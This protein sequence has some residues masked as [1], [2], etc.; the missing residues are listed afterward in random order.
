MQKVGIPLFFKGGKLSIDNNWK[1]RYSSVRQVCRRVELFRSLKNLIG[2]TVRALDGNIGT[3]ADFYIDDFDWMVKYVV[4][5]VEGTQVPRLSLLAPLAFGDLENTPEEGVFPVQVTRAT[6]LN[7]PLLR[8][9]EPVSLRHLTAIHSY[10][11]WPIYWEIGGSAEP[12][13]IEEDMSGYPIVEM[14]TDV[15]AQRDAFSHSE[16]PHL[17]SVKEV[18]GYYINTR[19]GVQAA[20]VVDFLAED[21]DWRVM[22]MVANAG[23]KAENRYVLLSP[24][25]VDEIHWPDHEINLDLKT[26]TVQK[27]PPYDPEMI[28][29]REYEEQLFHHYNRKA[30]WSRE[31]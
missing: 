21:E 7:S 19:D 14:M 29:D 25:W 3:V 13:P 8:Q 11:Q 12:G 24:T 17:R 6:I 18:V 5:Q 16:D 28:L 20:H 4:V 2:S 23:S 1:R 31:K 10:Y 26:E 22:Y 15:E 30:Y 27:S 9:E